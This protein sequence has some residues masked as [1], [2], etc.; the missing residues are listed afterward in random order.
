MSG[1]QYASTLLV[2]EGTISHGR[3]ISYF[4]GSK[5]GQSVPPV[6]G[7]SQVPLVQ[8]NQYAKVG[9][10]RVAYSAP[11]HTQGETVT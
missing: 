7:I 9:Y 5:E 11:L 10:P 1:D 8:N 3:F 2:D 4:K 6:S